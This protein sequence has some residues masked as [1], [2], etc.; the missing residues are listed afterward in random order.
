[1]N[2]LKP[3]RTQIIIIIIIISLEI[4]LG[5]VKKLLVYPHLLSRAEYFSDRAGLTLLPIL[6]VGLDW[7]FGIGSDLVSEYGEDE[8]LM[9][10]LAHVALGHEHRPTARLCVGFGKS[11][12]SIRKPSS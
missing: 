1:M 7:S 9:T 2:T 6:M 8:G 4:A 10:A 11:I 3:D 12:N 5:Q